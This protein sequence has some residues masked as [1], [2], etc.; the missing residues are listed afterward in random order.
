MMEQS[1]HFKNRL[2]MTV[3]VA[4]LMPLA[5]A[6]QNARKQ[7][8]DDFYGLYY[9]DWENQES[10]LAL[11]ISSN[12]QPIPPKANDEEAPTHPGFYVGVQHFQFASSRFSPQGFS[13]R[14]RSVDG[15]LFT[16]RGRF[17]REQVDIIPEVPYL[18][19]VLKEVRNGR[20]VRKEK[21]HFGHAVIL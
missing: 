4:L 18:V 5:S 13:F 10:N 2:L 3:F 6:D 12:G 8:F 17:G 15:R 21:V 1:A 16:F 14:T 20:I 19:G 9:A 7:S 11:V